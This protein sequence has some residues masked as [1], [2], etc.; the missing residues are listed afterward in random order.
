VNSYPHYDVAII[1]GGPAG[2]TAA[3]A[4]VRHGAKVALF[5]ERLAAQTAR[6][7]ETLQARLK[8]VLT[9]LGMDDVIAASTLTTASGVASSWSGPSVREWPSIL[10]PH[11]PALH[12]ER[13]AFRSAL[14][15]LTAESGVHLFVG[16]R[17]RAVRWPQGWQVSYRS[18]LIK[19]PFLIVATGRN[20]L[21]I[22]ANVSRRPVDRLIAVMTSARGLERI[23]DSRL[24]V[25]AAHDGW[26]YRCPS[27]D[28]YQQIAFLSDADIIGD[29]T[30][31]SDKW[32]VKR[33]NQ[34]DLGRALSI[35]GPVRIVAAN[36]YYRDSV[37]GDNIMLIGDAAFAGDPLAGQGITWAVDSAVYGATIVS[38]NI[39][40]R[41]EALDGYSKAVEIWI[42][43][44]LNRRFHVYSQVTNWPNS[45]F[46]RR[47]R[48][49]ILSSALAS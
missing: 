45:S 13:S 46:W 37:V 5:E 20:A 24:I 47:R 32:F 22:A 1:G 31:S 16:G 19:A 33:A 44:F 36:T 29:A 48:A 43:E 17:V 14:A 27:C 11:G 3:M 7:V 25:E 8:P 9:E 21:P 2:L 10:D 40:R 18:D 30:R 23:D 49:P 38:S 35:E 28:G 26:W 41:E 39:G 34:T 42:V 15:T 12:I 4:L 6:R